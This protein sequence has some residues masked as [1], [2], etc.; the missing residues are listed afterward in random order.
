MTREYLLIML[1][2]M[3][4]AHIEN[5][6]ENGKIGYHESENLAERILNGLEDMKVLQLEE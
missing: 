3:I 4:D 2:K 6:G 1:D 5:D